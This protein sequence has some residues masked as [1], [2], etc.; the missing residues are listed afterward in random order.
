M[1]RVEYLVK[2]ALRVAFGGSHYLFALLSLD[3]KNQI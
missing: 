3:L 2:A 1:H